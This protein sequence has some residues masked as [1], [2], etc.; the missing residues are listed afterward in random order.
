MLGK[1]LL[2]EQ[3]VDF[4]KCNGKRCK[5]CDNVTETSTFTSTETQNTYKI[6]QQF[7]CS[8]KYLVYLLQIL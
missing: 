6:N 3:T 7:N 5:V 4:C 8:K 2:I 1:T